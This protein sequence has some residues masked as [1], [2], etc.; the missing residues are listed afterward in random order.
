MT[1]SLRNLLEHLEGLQYDEEASASRQPDYPVH[2][3]ILNRWSPRS[4]AVNKPVSDEVLFTV[5]EAARWAPSGG[6]QQPWRFYVAR[7]PEEH[8]AF[9]SFIRPR[10]QLWTVNAPVL[11][12]IGSVTVRESGEPLNTH[13]FDTGAAWAAI[14][15]QANL[16]GLSTRAVGGFDQAAARELLQ[17]SEQIQLHAVIALGY[18]GDKET[19][20]PEFH[21]QEKPNSRRP[22]ADSIL[23]IVPKV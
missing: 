12:L 5:L 23:P 2:P 10:N 11:I 1:Q 18:R 22:L 19:L 3:L 21:E 15:Y 13:A 14:A 8:A 17:V 20:D 4:Y 6:N 9:Q 16:L 7:L